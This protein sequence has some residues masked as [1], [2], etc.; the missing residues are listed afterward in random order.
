MLQV[1]I[2]WKAGAGRSLIPLHM[3]ELVKCFL[4]LPLSRIQSSDFS[5]YEMIYVRRFVKGKDEHQGKKMPSSTKARLSTSLWSKEKEDDSS[6][7]CT[8][9]KQIRYR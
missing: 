5:A 4:P 8:C 9:F 2:L 3:K 1:L 6:C 7:E